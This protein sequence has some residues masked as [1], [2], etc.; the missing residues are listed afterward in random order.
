MFWREAFLAS[1]LGLL[2]Y[3][4]SY[5]LEQLLLMKALGCSQHR[6]LTA[7]QETAREEAT[8]LPHGLEEVVKRE[9]S[10]EDR[11]QEEATRREHAE[12]AAREAADAVWLRRSPS[13]R[14][15][16]DAWLWKAK[17]ETSKSWWL[18]L[19]KSGGRHM[20]QRMHYTWNAKG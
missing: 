8:G 4:S 2:S 18:W 17:P 14:P 13:T 20:Q 3:L 9:E 12:A 10:T 7:S 19:Y 5:A 16:R 15:S 1:T 6:A 11:L